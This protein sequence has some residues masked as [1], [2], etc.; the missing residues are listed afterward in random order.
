MLKYIFSALGVVMFLVLFIS[1]L[2]TGKL[3]ELNIHLTAYGFI[4]AG[5]GYIIETLKKREKDSADHLKYILNKNQNELV[6]EIRTI[7]T[8]VFKM[9]TRKNDQPQID[10]QK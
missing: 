4:L 5:L 3:S 7:R 8:M 1:Y 9:Q 6:D 10:D 2:I